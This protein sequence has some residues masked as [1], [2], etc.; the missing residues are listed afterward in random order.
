MADL[1]DLLGGIGSFLTGL[2]AVAAVVFGGLQA[3]KELEKRRDER[4]HARQLE[5][6]IRKAERGERLYGKRS[7]IATHLAIAAKHFLVSVQVASSPWYA[8]TDRTDR[9]TIE[10]RLQRRWDEA[11]EPLKA[12][13]DAWTLAQIFLPDD[14][15]QLCNEM[16]ALRNE[17]L[18]NQRTWLSTLNVPNLGDTPYY[19]KGMGT[20]PH[21]RAEGLMA[22]T[23]EVL[24]P[25]ARMHVE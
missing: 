8:E 2:A 5:A 24:R 3:R 9:Q 10:E 15:D 13:L 11:R 21:E 6:D 14:V 20:G 23:L 12:F 16:W 25:Y 19:R 1:G 18:A 22:K 17:V 7:E 4:E